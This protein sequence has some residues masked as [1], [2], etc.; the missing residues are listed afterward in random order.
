M[1]PLLF[2]PDYNGVVLEFFM[3]HLW[4]NNDGW[5]LIFY[6][7]KQN[8]SPAI[9]N[10]NSNIKI[11]KKRPDLHVVIPNIIYGIETGVGIPETYTP[12]EKVHVKE[13]LSNKLDQLEDEGYCEEEIVEELTSLAHENGFLLSHIVPDDYEDQDKTLLQTIKDHFASYND[14]IHSGYGRKGPALPRRPSVKG[15]HRLQQ[16]QLRTQTSMMDVGYHPW[17][18]QEKAAAFVKG[19]D[20]KTVKKTWGMLYCGGSKPVE[21]TLRHISEDYRIALYPESFAW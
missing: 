17:E 3:D 2:L 6:T 20:K 5:I 4:L 21:A 16:R 15:Y 13:I 19:L 14:G 8:L 7:G 12:S 10:S 18:E 11:I 1:F 9:E